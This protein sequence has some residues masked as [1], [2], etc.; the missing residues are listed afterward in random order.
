MSNF[1]FVEQ[2]LAS[3]QA[4]L[5]LAL[6]SNINHDSQS[7]AVAINDAQRLINYAHHQMEQKIG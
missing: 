7:I 3:A 6:T 1:S 4:E 5:Q 2:L